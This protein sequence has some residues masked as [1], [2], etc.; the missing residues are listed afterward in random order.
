MSESSHLPPEFSRQ[1]FYTPDEL[2]RILR[3]HVSTIREWVRSDRLFAYRISER[4]IR[5]PLGSVMELL[6]ESQPVTRRTLTPAE[7]AAAWK[8]AEV[9]E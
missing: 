6:G 1:A 9:R 4:V 8:E 5:I 2:A 3:V 7:E